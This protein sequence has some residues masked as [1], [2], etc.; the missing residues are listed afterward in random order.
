MKITLEGSVA[1]LTSMVLEVL[2]DADGADDNEEIVVDTKDNDEANEKVVEL[3]YAIRRA[4]LI[5][6]QVIDRKGSRVTADLMAELNIWRTANAY[7]V[8]GAGN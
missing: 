2:N 3:L 7:F 5:M 4:D 8:A 6:K 1:E